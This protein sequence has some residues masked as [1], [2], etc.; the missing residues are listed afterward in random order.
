MKK[1]KV[2]DKVKILPR[3]KTIPSYPF[4]YV[5]EMEKYVGTIQV[6]ARIDNSDIPKMFGPLFD[7]DLH[8]YK[9]EDI[10]FTWHS[11]M[12]EPYSPEQVS[13]DVP[14]LEINC[15]KKIKIIL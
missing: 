10:R 13:I 7:K 15:S 2:G 6:I 1:Y 8:S 3:D 9:F 12:F 14:T 4:S 5:S 11:S